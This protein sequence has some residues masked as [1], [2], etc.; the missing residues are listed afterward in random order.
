MSEGRIGSA[1]QQMI[2]FKIGKWSDVTDLIMNMG[3]EIKEWEH[4]KNNESCGLDD[5]DI[6][7]IDEYF[8]K[9]QKE[10]KDNE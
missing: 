5:K 9:L 3:L 4:I 8:T 1:L 7:E 10:V 2:G 6:E